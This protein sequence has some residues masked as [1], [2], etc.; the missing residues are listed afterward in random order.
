MNKLQ[1]AET[2]I[3]SYEGTLS[4]IGE[5]LGVTP[6][7]VPALLE[8]IEA[9]IGQEAELEALRLK[10]VENEWPEQSVIAEERDAALLKL[11]KLQQTA[12]EQYA[13]LTG[14]AE[15]AESR[16]GSVED[17][18]HSLRTW[19]RELRDTQEDRGQEPA[20][21]L[22]SMLL[23]R[24]ESLMQADPAPD[25]AEGVRLVALADLCEAYEKRKGSWPTAV[26][27]SA[28]KSD[29]RCAALTTDDGSRCS[30]HDGHAGEHT[31]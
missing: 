12:A 28:L 8:R 27:T 1:A 6:G 31:V 16:L 30:Q 18:N 19:I 15:R 9:L 29:G 25:S 11:G 7:D 2:M 14:R 17:Q 20:D 3:E 26:E 21:P 5:R 10:Q 24:I 23:E 13:A 22:Y 4:H